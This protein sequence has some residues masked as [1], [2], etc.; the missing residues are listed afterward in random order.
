MS[1]GSHSGQ[2]RLVRINALIE[3]MRKNVSLIGMLFP[4]GSS[5]VLS[6]ATVRPQ[7]ATVDIPVVSGNSVAS[8]PFVEITS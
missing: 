8:P 4:T 7:S 2:D 1:G 6:L 3:A 5:P